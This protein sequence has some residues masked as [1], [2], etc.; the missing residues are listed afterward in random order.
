MALPGQPLTLSRE[1]RA[2]PTLLHMYCHLIDWW[3]RGSSTPESVLHRLLLHL[4]LPRRWHAESL[5][6]N[7]ALEPTGM[8]QTA[9][10][11][12]DLLYLALPALPCLVKVMHV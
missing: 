12:F 1:S 8:R 10:T 2:F 6:L 4:T 9:L 5:A 7:S 11:L 3:Q